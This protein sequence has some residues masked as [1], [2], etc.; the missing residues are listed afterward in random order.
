[1]NRKSTFDWIPFYEEL[2]NKLVLY[3]P[4]QQEL[5]DFLEELRAQGLKITPLEDKDETGRRFVLREIDPFTFFGSFNRGIVTETRVRILQA[6]KSRFGVSAPVPSDFTGVPVLNNQQS[7]FIAYQAKRKPG[8]VDRLWK[9]FIGAL[10]EA[11]LSDLAFAKAFDEA[12][13]VWGT[14]IN[15]TIGLFWIQPDRFLSLDSNIRNHLKIKL[16]SD[17]LSF[18]FYRRSLEQVR[19]HVK[20]D[21]PHL[22]HSAWLAGKEST[23]P[24]QQPRTEPQPD[25]DIDYWMVGAYWDEDDPKDQAERFLAEGVWENGYK[26]RYLDPVKDMKVGDRIAIKAASTQKE[27]L[28][29]DNRGNTVSRMTIKAR[30]TVVSNPGDGRSVEV[31]WEPSPAQLR[32][33]YFYTGRSTVWRLRKDNEFAQR[34]IRFAFYDEPQDYSFFIRKWW[35]EAETAVPP[36]KEIDQNVKPYAVEDLLAEGV[37]LSEP[38]INRALSRWKVKKNLVLQGAPGVGKTFISK[39]LSYALMEERD[40]KRITV[41]QFHP[42]Y[43]YE[44][45]VRGYRPTSEPGKFELVDGPFLRLC[46]D[47]NNDRDSIYVLVIEE[48]N[49][50]NLSQIFGE[51][52]TLL[53]ADKRGK[54]HELTP[55][56][57]RSGHEALFVPENLHVIGTMNIA[58]RSLALVDYA[59]R[60]R[61]AFLTLEPRF[62][63]PI[64][65]NWLKERGMSDALCHH[66][67]T[68][69]TGLNARIAE[70]SQLGPAFRIGH[71]FFCPGGR[72]FSGLDEHWYRDIIETEIVPL[73]N[74]YWYDAPDKAKSAAEELLV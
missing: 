14:N 45:F 37:F 67:I 51:L 4:R 28:P 15:L 39:R 71:S 12:L 74:E 69:M 16:P 33:W 32:D 73:L 68:R 27:G 49:R 58:D 24:A 2:A 48:I 44:D 40:D 30:G 18:D 46:L 72:D 54:Y 5:I 57:Q 3:Q 41:V 22:S 56:Y 11:P 6:M 43:S 61:F 7:W 42:S 47:A 26:D 8:D 59:L 55:L 50:G 52:I 62:D 10:G 34:L 70:D 1:M 60:R 35:D 53:E 29:F 65:R 31:E 64:F 19:R 17:G 63:D 13:A 23:S 20:E 25:S 9:V 36:L 66:I 38:Q 21:F